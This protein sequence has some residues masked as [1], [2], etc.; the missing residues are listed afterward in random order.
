MAPFESI[1]SG[2][3]DHP[4]AGVAP[5]VPLSFETRAVQPCRPPARRGDAS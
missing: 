3:A 2:I 1:A 4:G 5:T